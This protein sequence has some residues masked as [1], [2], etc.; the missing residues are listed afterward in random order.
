ME[1][2][3]EKQQKDFLNLYNMY[4]TYL[5]EYELGHEFVPFN[6]SNPTPPNGIFPS[7]HMDDFRESIKE[8]AHTIKVKYGY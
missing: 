7:Y 2:I 1:I 4:Y 5:C 3:K 6:N 8:E